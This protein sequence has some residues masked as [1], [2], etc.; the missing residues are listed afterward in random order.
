M[1]EVSEHSPWSFVSKNCPS[2]LLPNVDVMSPIAE[3]KAGRR[4][5]YVQNKQIPPICSFLARVTGG[6]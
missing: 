1:N 2:S 5:P 6:I 3:T 4:R